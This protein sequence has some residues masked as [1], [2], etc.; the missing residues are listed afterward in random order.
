[1]R[2]KPDDVSTK[3]GLLAEH[4]H[5]EVNLMRAAY[6][7]LKR[8]TLQ[9]Q[10]DRLKEQIAMNRFEHSVVSKAMRGL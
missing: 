3:S 8:Y 9:K 4:L 6:D 1:M 5:Y 7:N 2:S 10:A